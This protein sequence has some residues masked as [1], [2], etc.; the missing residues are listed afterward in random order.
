MSYIKRRIITEKKIKK[1]KK[2]YQAQQF[3]EIKSRQK[4]TT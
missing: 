4:L 2:I 3:V 1:K